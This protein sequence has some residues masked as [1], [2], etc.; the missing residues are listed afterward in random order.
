MPL[1]KT[2]KNPRILLLASI[3]FIFT[4]V[5]G[6]YFLYKPSNKIPVAKGGTATTTYIGASGGNWSESGNWDNGVP[7][8]VK[9]AVIVST[10]ASITVVA[11][12]GID[13]DTLV[14]GGNATYNATLTL[15]NSIANGANITIGDNGILTQ[16]NATAQTISGNLTIESGGK[17][18]H[19][20]NTTA[21]SYIISFNVQGNIDVQS[22]GTIDV[23]GLGY[24]GQGNTVGLGLGAGGF[25][26]N[27]GGGGGH[28]GN[29]GVGNHASA[30][31]GL[32]YCDISNPATVGSSG[33]AY[34]GGTPGESGGG[35]IILNAT[36][37][38]T[39]NGTITADGNGAGGADYH[40]GGSGG[41]VK[42]TADT[43]AGTPTSFTITGGDGGSVFGGRGGGGGGGCAYVEYTT[44][45]SM[46][47]TSIAMN[48]GANGYQKGGAGQVLI[49]DSD[50]GNGDLFVINDGV[51]AAS[52]S[53]LI[54]T[55][56]TLD[57]IYI[58]NFSTYSVSSS[59]VITTVTVSSTSILEIDAGETLTYTNLLGDATATGVIDVYGT[60]TN[61]SSITTFDHDINVVV[62]SGG[63]FNN[64]DSLVID[65]LGDL[66]FNNGAILS[67]TELSSLS[68]SSTFN[69][70][71]SN[72]VSVGAFTIA[73]DTVTIS[74]FTT[75][76][77]PLSVTNLVINN[78]GTLTHGDNS[79][80]QS[81]IINIAATG[82]ITINS[83]STI[84]VDGLGYDGQLNGVGLGLGAGGFAGNTG[85]GGGHG[86]AGG[87]GFD[88]SATGGSAYCVSTTLD[89]IGSSGGAYDHGLAGASG[90]GLIILQA[91]STITIDGAITADGA[92][93]TDYNGGG[94]GGGVK[95]IAST[96]TGTPTSFTTTGGNGGNAFGGRGGGGG[97]GCTYIGYGSANADIIV[98]TTAYYS[99]DGSATGFE[100]GGDGVFLAE[101]T[102]TAPTA[103]SLTA[104]QYSE[105]GTLVEIQVTVD[106]DDNDDLKMKVE[107]MD[108]AA[109]T[110]FDK[111]PKMI[112]NPLTVSNGSA[113]PTL[114]DAATYQFGATGD[115][116]DTSLGVNT[117]TMYWQA[118]DDEVDN[119][120]TYCIGVTVN[121]GTVDGTIVTQTVSLDLISPT[122]P[123]DLT[124]NTTSTDSVIFNFGS[125]SSDT[126][127]N[128]YVIAYNVGSV[129]D[130]A[131]ADEV[132]PGDDS[133]L[134]SANYG[135]ASTT[136]LTGLVTSTQYTANITAY[137]NSDNSAE[138]ASEITFYTLADTAGT[139]TA[140]TPTANTVP[141]TIDTA[142]NP[143]TT[144]YA[145]Y[146]ATDNNYLAADGSDNSG[147]AVWQTTSTWGAS[148]AATGLTVNTSYQFTVV[149]RN[150]DNIQTAT[151]TAS[152]AA[153]TLANA[154]GTPTVDN[155]TATTLDVTL[156]VNSNPSNT[157]YSIYNDTDSVWLDSAGAAT[158]T[159]VYQ[160]S[161][162]WAASFTATG[163]SANTAYQFTAVA[164]NGDNTDAA[165][166]TA[167][168]ALYTL[169]NAPGA[170]TVDGATI[171]SLDVTIDTNSNPA[172]T[173]YAIYESSTG[174]YVAADN[175]LDATTAVYQ[176]STE[177]GTGGVAT[178]T[179][180][181][182]NTS[183]TFS[184]VARNGDNIDTA[185]TTASA[186]YTIVSVPSAPTLTVNSPTQ[187]TANYS[188]TVYQYYVENTTKGSTS[189]WTTATNWVSTDLACNTT[190]S[191]RVKGRNQAETETSYSSTASATTQACTTG[192]Y[193]APAAPSVVVVPNSPTGQTITTSQ[194]TSGN[195]N[196]NFS[197]SNVKQMAI[198][199]SKDFSN[200]SWIPY[201]TP[202]PYNVNQ[203]TTL[204]IK[205]RSEAGGESKVLTVKVKANPTNTTNNNTTTSGQTTPNIVTKPSTP[206]TPT[207]TVTTNHTFTKYLTIGHKS[208][209]VKQLQ[210]LLKQLGHF[211]YPTITGYFGN[212]TKQAV[213]KFQQK[214][215]KTLGSAPGW[216]GPKTR[217]L[218]NELQT[219]TTTTEEEKK[220]TP[221]KPT[222][223]NTSK[224]TFTKYLT[225]GS[226]GEEVKQLQN[227]LK[228]LGHFTYPTATGY[229][230][231]I[232]KTAVIKFQKA[233]NLAP[234]PGWVG[235]GTRGVLNQ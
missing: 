83:G 19:T 43:I 106:D 164:R 107:Y 79:T 194:T 227:K 21:Q 170:V 110:G 130:D 48:G 217:I 7:S 34:D 24:D 230:G 148:F 23:D 27:M 177:W 84:D 29:G 157:T 235:P 56:A 144:E 155:A 205:F 99:L 228:E 185:T 32:G 223:P 119:E 101:M 142:T 167:S 174:N 226:N 55:P 52:S 50:N 134:G 126:N 38:I 11:D 80:A 182:V 5:L 17:L 54:G 140:G 81:H 98:S 178:V 154:A 162:T 36:S 41:G 184:M 13:F 16:N 113:P 33:G 49:K 92:N 71:Q 39:I 195:T 203:D 186:V 190:Y 75:S 147:T 68:S 212:I 112:S 199:N 35:L 1:I 118:V 114:D 4:F 115:P 121:D 2:L 63:T 104:S 189:G 123:G 62:Y 14:L 42:I 67:D 3:I 188:G 198:S 18:T 234:Y 221:T 158:S 20:N 102:N 171:S 215:I 73:T 85:G 40:G 216:V 146:N 168:T 165:T 197:V 153:Y 131:I 222:T 151:S 149:A 45:N 137:D 179:G 180:L 28:G 122:T 91:T 95:I 141:V 218:L 219:K 22:G 30:T 173:N 172:S 181:T 64:G 214:H 117:I 209:E 132:G 159:A 70:S 109:C 211:T 191:F 57:S 201:V 46:T 176:T 12:T 229:Y 125:Q 163:L 136:T 74:D 111:D 213:I 124:M 145:I 156:D 82:N 69:F 96:V 37:T 166:S 78:G 89:T 193:T 26:N 76:T 150:G 60:Y 6:I 59:L 206:T 133:N 88:A 204:Y 61:A 192:G 232:T 25:G 187:I 97:G 143:T 202:Y 65:S 116:L 100:A 86:G 15:T 93:A 94:S 138:S 72:F 139:P 53:V 169:A 77:G 44:S 225:I 210:T 220:D 8:N 231:N 196:L 10:T 224:Y 90:G 207:P 175:G 127:F 233:N 152:T 105:D 87:R 47:T 103:T 51:V 160:A 208:E 58:D 128:E 108:G 120:G 200:T 161:S 129:F 31:G 135:G 9:D 66:T 183:Y